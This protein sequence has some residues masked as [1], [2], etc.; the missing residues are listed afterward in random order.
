MQWLEKYTFPTE[1]RFSNMDFAHDVY[2][3]SV[4]RHLSYGTTTCCYYGTIHVEPT[5]LLARLAETAGQRAFIGKVCMD[6]NAP[7]SY[8][9]TSEQS[10]SETHRFLSEMKQQHFSLVSPIITPRFIPTCSDELLRNLAQ[11]A[12]Q[13]ALPLQTHISESPAEV[14]FV[15]SLCSCNYTDAYA[16]TGILTPRTILAHGVHLTDPE[17]QVIKHHESAIS[18]CPNSNYT[19]DSGCL[20]VRQVL[21]HGIKVGLGT[22]V[23]GGYSPSILD[24][25]R[26]A[27]VCS[28][29]LM[30]Q[31]KLEEQLSYVEA[32][33]LATLGGAQVVGMENQIGNF[34]VGKDFD[35]LI[36]NP[37][38]ATSPFDIFEADSRTDI[39]EKFLYMGDDRNIET[40]F[41]AGKQLTKGILLNN[42][43]Q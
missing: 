16:R 41:V 34:L 26:L 3:K 38:S 23:A 2:S 10:L 43:A 22:D 37:C 1:S 39:F 12:Q 4:S 21:Q 28:K 17:L 42:Q 9:E 29:S 14:A 40:V 11:L 8:V 25:I 27:M 7:D 36:I 32:F 18:H 5:I 19:L 31:G 6:R 20:N 35:A 15:E 33:F 30:F 13:E 24:A